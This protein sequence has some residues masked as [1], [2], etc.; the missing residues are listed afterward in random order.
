MLAARMVVFFYTEDST[1]N[2]EFL[3][4]DLDSDSCRYAVL[5]LT[6]IYRIQL[7]FRSYFLRES[8][9]RGL[10]SWSFE[11]FLTWFSPRAMFK[12]GGFPIFFL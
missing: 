11:V 2:P 8:H 3:C 10:F 12:V 4:M 7:H 6:Q 9:L 1:S 5:S